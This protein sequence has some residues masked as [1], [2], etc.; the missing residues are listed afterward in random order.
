VGGVTPVAVARH[1]A[2]HNPMFEDI[3]IRCEPGPEVGLSVAAR[4]RRRERLAVSEPHA[5]KQSAT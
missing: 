3:V 2:R 1:D 4:G 5:S